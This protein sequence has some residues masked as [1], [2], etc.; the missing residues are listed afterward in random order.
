MAQEQNLQTHTRLDPLF[1]FFLGPASFV[2]FVA[3][4]VNIIRNPGW[5]AAVYVLAGIWAVIATFKIRLYALKVQDRVIRLEERLRMRDLLGPAFQPRILELTTDQ[6]IGLRFAGDDELPSLVER[7][8]A[9][10]WNRK[11]IKAAVKT[12]RPDHFRV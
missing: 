12:W 5:R 9:E 10:N 1:H 8:L 4:V 7:T 2:L 6:C 3:A 11:Q